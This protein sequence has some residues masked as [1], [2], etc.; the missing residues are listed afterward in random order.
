MRRSGCP[1]AVAQPLFR[2]RSWAATSASGWT[3]R[4]FCRDRS[5]RLSTRDR[6]D[7]WNGL[8]KRSS[9]Q[10]HRSARVQAATPSRPGSGPRNTRAARAACSASPSRWRPTGLGPV[11]EGPRGLRRC[12]GSPRHARP[13]APC[14]R[15]SPR[16][17]G[18]CPPTRWR[19]PASASAAR[20]F[21]SCRACRRS[22]SGVKSP[23]IGSAALIIPSLVG[24]CS[25]RPGEH[26]APRPE[27][28]FI[29]SPV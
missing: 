18:S 29:R 15:A 28:Q 17:P 14:R 9:S 5:R 2:K 10:K 24:R 19:S 21:A 11:V 6:L 22:A 7:G 20:R 3:G 25:R 16:P 13:A 1:Q 12:S 4:V 8:P 26:A 27:S 23:R